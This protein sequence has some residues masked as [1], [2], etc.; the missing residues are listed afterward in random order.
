MPSGMKVEH[1]DYVPGLTSTC[2][3]GIRNYKDFRFGGLG[4]VFFRGQIWQFITVI[5][6]PI[7][8]SE[9]CINWKFLFR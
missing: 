2:G 1:E 6:F 8:V 9:L 7:S 4:L 3:A 5:Y